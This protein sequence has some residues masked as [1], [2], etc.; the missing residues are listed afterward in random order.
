MRETP[1]WTTSVVL[2]TTLTCLAAALSGC[3]GSE[4]EPA[5]GPL[6]AVRTVP[7]PEGAAYL[8]MHLSA[9]LEDRRRAMTDLEADLGRTVVLDRVYHRF[10]AD[11]PTAY[12]RWSVARGRTLFLGWS[13]RTTDGVVDWREVADGAW[14]DVIDARAA[15]VAELDVPV[16]IS[17]CHEPGTYLGEERSGTTEDFVA[18]WRH[19]VTRF[20]EAGTATSWVWTLTAY[21]F[22]EGE[23][24]AW[25][26]GDDVVDWVGVDGYVNV[27]CPWLDVPWRTWTETFTD[28]HAFAAEHDKPLAVAEFSLRE[29]PADPE[30]K[31]AWL[32]D[33]AAEVA[34]MP[35]LRAVVGFNSVESCSDQV[36]STPEALA[37]L[38]SLAHSDALSARPGQPG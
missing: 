8:G 32:S 6:P 17:F 28:A 35:R 11:F 9:T 31:G 21:A 3:T 27:D 15:A 7:V 14:D 2:A 16:M 12:D 20:A 38:R 4:Q 19:V 26:P 24:P 10:D 37:G 22:R 18:A 23:A 36:A 33:A 29:D 34:A 30:R 1:R 5:P 25:Y 13:C